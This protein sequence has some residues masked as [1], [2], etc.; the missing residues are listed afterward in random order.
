VIVEPGSYRVQVDGL[1]FGYSVKSI[2]FGS[3][4]VLKEPFTIAQGDT[5]SLVVALT[6]QPAENS[7]PGVR[8]TAR[9]TDVP[10]TL[11]T[12][13]I[14]L[15]LVS[16]AKEGVRAGV[17]QASASS[18]F[19][20]T[21]VPPGTYT[22]TAIPNVSFPTGYTW[23]GQSQKSIVVTNQNQRVELPL[24]DGVEVQGKV[25]NTDG[26]APAAA[27]AFVL[28]DRV[29]TA[30]VPT[31]HMEIRLPPDGTFGIWLPEGE[32]RVR[33]SA[34]GANGGTAP[35]S[36]R[37]I[38][39]GSIDLLANTLKSDGHSAIAPIVVTVQ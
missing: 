23:T 25:V 6:K 17:A 36:T 7:A 20:F 27:I 35:F 1:P 14:Q 19:E 8:V 38:T 28:F 15:T 37:T 2:A 11:K 30:E 22:V 33:F 26:N 16:N 29:A 5:S 13:R 32:Y 21:N 39:S 4:D 12:D 10:G 31:N 18:E 24:L 3:R 9:L 34:Y